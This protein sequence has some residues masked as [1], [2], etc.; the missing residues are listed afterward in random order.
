M[1]ELKGSY[2][3]DRI[4]IQKYKK[5]VRIEVVCNGAGFSIMYPVDKLIKYLKESNNVLMEENNGITKSNGIK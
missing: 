2:G 4:I 3:Y 1:I 5:N